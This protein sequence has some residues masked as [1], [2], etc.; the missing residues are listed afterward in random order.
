[1]IFFPELR[2][3]IAEV[4]AVI[5]RDEGPDLD[6]AQQRVVDAYR[7]EL[8]SSVLRGSWSC[9][10]PRVPWTTSD[11]YCSP[12]FQHA[13]WFR[14]RGARGLRSWDDCAVVGGPYRSEVVDEDGDFT[15]DFLAAAKPLLRHGLGVWTNDALSWWYPV[16]RFAFWSRWASNLSVPVHSSFVRGTTSL[17]TSPPARAGEGNCAYHTAIGASDL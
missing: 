17:R 13:V 14:R 3:A 12:L 2:A 8:L 15:S 6:I 7:N 16:R 11:R 1:L 10:R 4:A 5:G 9:G